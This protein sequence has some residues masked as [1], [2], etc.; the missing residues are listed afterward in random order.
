MVAFGGVVVYETP[1]KKRWVAFEDYAAL[2]ENTR[3]SENDALV[4]EWA[5]EMFS[6]TAEQ[7]DGK[8][9]SEKS[10]QD[11]ENVLRA[12]KIMEDILEARE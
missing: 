1:D 5:I 8:W 7:L 2:R 4:L 10:R 12:V 11:C 6:D 9:D 3:L